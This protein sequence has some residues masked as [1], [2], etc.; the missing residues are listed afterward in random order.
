[1]YQTVLATLSGMLLNKILYRTGHI[2]LNFIFRVFFRLSVRGAEKVPATGGVLIAANH[3]SF[4]DPPVVGCCIRREIYYFARKTLFDHWLLR[5]LL[6]KIN[7]IP[8]DQEKPDLAGIRSALRILQQ[9][10]G[11]LIFPEG[12]RTFDG[13]LQQGRPGLGLLVA[14]SRVPVI[15]VRIRGTFEAWPRTRKSIRLHPIRVTFGDPIQ[16][17]PPSPGI[18]MEQYYRQI[19]QDILGKIASL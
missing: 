5:W 15:P 18:S 12:A 10:H 11:L 3:A 8:I 4:L 6:P 19:S 13:K 7:A 2:L 1:M 14:K 17:S 9:G 16:I